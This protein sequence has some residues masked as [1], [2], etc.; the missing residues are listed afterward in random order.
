MQSSI[1]AIFSALCLPLLDITMKYSH[2]NKENN[3]QSAT[4]DCV[5]FHSH[6]SKHNLQAF[7]HTKGTYLSIKRLRRTRWHLAS[8][9]P[10][11]PIPNAAKIYN[12]S[13]AA[14][15]HVL[16]FLHSDKKNR[17]GGC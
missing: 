2:S 4:R 13:A 10:V 15:Q 5:I 17:W 6:Q 11:A 8:R 9:S 12:L 1:T 16:L 14:L 3:R 7:K